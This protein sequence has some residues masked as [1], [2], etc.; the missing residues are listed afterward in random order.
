MLLSPRSKNGTSLLRE[1]PFLYEKEAGRNLFAL[2]V[3]SAS[4]RATAAAPFLIILSLPLSGLLPCILETGL[5][6]ALA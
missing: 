3:P 1:V 2:T 6:C 5:F 4:R